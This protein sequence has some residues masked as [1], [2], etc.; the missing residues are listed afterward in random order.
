M[1]VYLVRQSGW[2]YNK[3]VFNSTITLLIHNIYI[4]IFLKNAKLL[5]LYLQ[6][7]KDLTSRTYTLTAF[8][9]KGVSPLS[10]F[11]SNWHLGLKSFN[12]NKHKHIFK[13][14]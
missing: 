11:H 12:E 13:L 1:G 10:P 14:L 7:Q 9:A 8:E 3:T 4:Y 6:I 2:R 5:H